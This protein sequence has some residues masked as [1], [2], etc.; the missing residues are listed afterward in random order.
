MSESLQLRLVKAV[1]L[2]IQRDEV[3][4]EGQRIYFDLQSCTHSGPN[5]AD[6]HQASLLL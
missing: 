1:R 3:L 6:L 2:V 5:S 4:P